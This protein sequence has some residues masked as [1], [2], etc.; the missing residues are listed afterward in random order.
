MFKLGGMQ[1]E[2][3]IPSERNVHNQTVL[4]TPE[5]LN[6][7][8][9]SHVEDQ[10]SKRI[11]ELRQPSVS[12]TKL[13]AMAASVDTKSFSDVTSAEDATPADSTIE[14]TERSNNFSDNLVIALHNS[15]PQDLKDYITDLKNVNVIDEDVPRFAL[16]EGP[17]GTG[18]TDTAKA[19]AII[20]GK[21]L[22]V[23]SAGSIP[24]SYKN[25]GPIQLRKL[26]L[27]LV[28][29]NCL[30][31]LDELSGLTQRHNQSNNPDPGMMESFFSLIDEISE[32]DLFVIGT[33]NDAT[34]LPEPLKSRFGGAI[35]TLS[36]PDEDTRASIISYYICLNGMK[37]NLDADNYKELVRITDGFSAKI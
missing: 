23:V 21:N 22:K 11:T 7:L 19:I 31:V 15:C 5:L 13:A 1:P 37:N 36:L 17:P 25:S 35:F 4:A 33:V 16:F 9:K 8:V 6:S 28:G 27:P 20:C 2:D 32:K 26:L 34:N 12:M 29:K 14:W 24:N 30:I 10:V 18:K 3:V